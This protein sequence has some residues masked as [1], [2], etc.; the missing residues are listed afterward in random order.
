MTN[1]KNLDNKAIALTYDAPRAPKVIAKGFDDLADE[2][3]NLAQEHGV[4]LHQD[5]EL[6]NFLAELD[7]GEEIPREVYIIIAELIAWSYI[8]RG[9]EPENWNNI[10]NRIDQTI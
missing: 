3:I 5:T 2:I 8:L 10:H 1:N 4:L 9:L 6:A 7:I